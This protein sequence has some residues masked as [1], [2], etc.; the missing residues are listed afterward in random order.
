MEVFSFLDQI[1]LSGMIIHP[2]CTHEGSGLGNSVQAFANE[3][4]E[5]MVTKGLAIRGSRANKADQAIFDW[6]T[7]QD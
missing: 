6:L 3:Y 7:T 1:D 5:L 4:P 2:F